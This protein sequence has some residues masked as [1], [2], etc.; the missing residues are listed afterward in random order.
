[1]SRTEQYTAIAVGIGM[2]FLFDH[3]QLI[4]S[5][6]SLGRLASKAALVFGA[7]LVILV[8]PFIARKKKNDSDDRS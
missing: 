5:S 1:M 4:P 3:F 6:Y 7:G 8:W 2:Y